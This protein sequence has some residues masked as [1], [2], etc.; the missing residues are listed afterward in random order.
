MRI[1]SFDE[2]EEVSEWEEG[3]MACLEE[4]VLAGCPKVKKVG[5]G[6]KH[7]KRL[8]L[9]SYQALGTTEA[10][11]KFKEG[12]EF[13]DKIKSINPQVNIVIRY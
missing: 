10:K 8:K 3:A 7:L 9:F 13:W 5:E 6:L 2:L 12:G 1:E 11:E 4:L